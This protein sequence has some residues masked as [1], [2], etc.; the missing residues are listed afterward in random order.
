MEY[1]VGFKIVE[2]I[3]NFLDEKDFETLYIV[4]DSIVENLYG[5]YINALVRERDH[6]IY[7]M[8]PGEENKNMKEVL[9]LYDDLLAN[10]I[11]RKDLIV[12]L[13]GGVVG[14]LGGFVASTYKRGLKYIQIPTT[15][16]SQVDSSIGGKVGVDYGGYKNLIGAFYF[17]EKTFIDTYFLSS[18]SRRE[19]RSGL[20]E[21]FKYG[22]IS[23]FDLFLY[24]R[25]HLDKVY[26]KDRE[27]LNHLVRKSVVIKDK[28]VSKDKKDLGIRRI[29]NFGHTIGHGIESYYNFYKFTHGEAVI[30]GLIYESYI[31]KTLGLI[32]GDY[33]KIIYNT[34]SKLVPPYKFKNREIEKLLKLIE[35]DKKNISGEIT[36][37]L[38]TSK[39]QVEIFQ[40]IDKELIVRSLKGE[41]IDSKR[42]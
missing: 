26:R 32:D 21:V 4:T 37:V 36:M 3:R 12:T 19:I 9:S 14:D 15:L 22:L 35:K 27:V 28:I 39:G 2:E 20:G 34:L 10:N 18:L 13:G 5:E 23:D 1:V 17:P 41:W 16:I 33:F 38:P 11:D 31:G 8:E 25:K 7:S 24:T 42:M 30:L 40:N 29:L 6:Y